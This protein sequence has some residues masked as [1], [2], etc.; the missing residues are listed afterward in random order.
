MIDLKAAPHTLRYLSDTP[1][2][3]NIMQ[4]AKRSS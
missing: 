4:G 1:E 2:G 3:N